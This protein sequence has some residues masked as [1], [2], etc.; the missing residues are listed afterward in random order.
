MKNPYRFEA[1]WLI[2]I[3]MV[4]FLAFGLGPMAAAAE[5]GLGD[6]PLDPETYQRYL[7]IWPEEAVEALPASY[8]ARDDGIVTPAKN[9]GSCG[10]CW[11]FASVGAFE[12][13]LLKQFGFGPTDL[14]EQQQ[15]SCNLSMVGCC[16]GSSS[17]P[18]YWESAGPIYEACFPYA[19]SG[20]SC[21]TQ[22]TVA[23]SAASGCTQLSFRVTNWHTVSP[24]EAQFKTSLYND[25]PSYWR[26]TVYSDFNT[27]WNSGNP[28][29]VYVSQSGYSQLG[30]H[31]VLLI[32]WDDAKGAYL[33]KNSWGAA[34]GPNGDGTF[35]I[36][37]SGHY[38]NLGFGMSNFNLT[39]EPGWDYCV[40]PSSSDARYEFN[41]NDMWLIGE[42]S[43]GSCGEDNPII[44]WAFGGSWVLVRD[45]PSGTPSC[46][47][48]TFYWG[49]MSKN[50]D[51]INSTG[52]TGT[53]TLNPCSSLGGEIIGGDALAGPQ[54]ALDGG[55][56]CLVD[57]SGNQYNLTTT[58]MYIQGTAYLNNCGTCPLIG[59]AKGGA[60][61]F[62][63]DIPTGT[64][65]CKE[66]FVVVARTSTNSG[67]WHFVD[68]SGT[69]S[70]HFTP[71]SLA[72]EL[73]PPLEPGP[74]EK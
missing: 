26:F 59:M 66:G 67:R 42:T 8:D 3:L 7:Q 5:Y 16:G 20:T 29:D 49:D 11:A 54:G 70:I 48:S 51:W 52:G 65:A 35:W 72:R 43:G 46:V 15:V 73:E 53:G 27:Y 57:G 38:Y 56:Y 14:S 34:A 6:I 23:C 64:G 36:A 28:G 22:R 45:I 74:G 10:S 19:E 24:T 69:G 44:G 47:E 21:P 4:L 31:A 39:G 25:G 58:G 37:Y 41:K 63:V 61:S 1:K 30:G 55:T 9:Q 12:S 2:G 40:E 13:H 50:Y 62:Y 71:C 32:G 18:R 60:F 17:A 33:C 68:D